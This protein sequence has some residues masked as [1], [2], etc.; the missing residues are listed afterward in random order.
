MIDVSSLALHEVL[1]R[2][3]SM[4]LSGYQK[5]LE[6]QRQKT[7]NGTTTTAS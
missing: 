4:A 6:D 2:A 3:L 1:Y 7:K 5:W